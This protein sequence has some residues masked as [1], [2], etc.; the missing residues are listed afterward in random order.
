M[1]E[2][3]KPNPTQAQRILDTLTEAGSWV[4]GMYFFDIRI[5]QYHARIFELQRKGYVIEGRNKEGTNWKEYR[6][7]GVPRKEQPKT[8]GSLFKRNV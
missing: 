6:L 3:H 7:T 8:Q 2:G 1:N 4:D 5:T